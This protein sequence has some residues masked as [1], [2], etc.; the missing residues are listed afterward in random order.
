MP[1]TASSATLRRARPCTEEADRSAARRC[2]ARDQPAPN[3]P[4]AASTTSTYDSQSGMKASWANSTSGEP[5]GRLIDPSSP[6]TYSCSPRKPSSP[7]S[8]MTKLGTARR[9]KICAYSQPMTAPAATAAAT[10]TR[11]GSSRWTART[12]T[13]AADR[14]LTDPTDRSIWATRSTHTTPRAMTPTAAL[15]MVRFTRLALDRNTGFSAWNTVQ[16]TTRPATTGRMPSSPARSR[17]AKARTWPRAPERSCSRSSCRSLV[18]AA[19]GGAVV[20][21]V[22]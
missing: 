1:S 13:V 19:G 21:S 9:L 10:A 12:A 5:N 14:P 6:R 20:C 7:A 22:T 16:I 2:R 4:A 15:S 3:S 17:S 18:R 11:T 8:V